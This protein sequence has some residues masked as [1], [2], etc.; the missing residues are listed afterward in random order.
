MNKEKQEE[1]NWITIGRPSYLG[2]NKDEQVTQWN[3]EYG[4]GGW[5]L[6]WQLASGEV[7]GFSE[8]FQ[9]Y[10]D[11]YTLYFELHLDEAYFLTDNFAYTYDKDL[12]SKEESFN[13]YALYFLPGRPNQFHH[14][15]LNHALEFRLLLEFKGDKPLQVREGKPG[16]DPNTW[17]AGWRWSPGRIPAAHPELIPQSALSDWWQSG[18]I[19]DLYQSAKILQIK[20]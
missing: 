6:A 11:S 13:P 16:T 1:Q 3:R 8:I 15:A 12:V 10:V 7:L 9:L 4:E 18:S 20:K 14:V 17:P 19:E 5:R 2:K